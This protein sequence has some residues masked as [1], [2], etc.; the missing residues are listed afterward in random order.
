MWTENDK[1]KDIEKKH[2]LVMLFVDKSNKTNKK[3]TVMDETKVII[4]MTNAPIS[5]TIQQKA[6]NIAEYMYL[7]IY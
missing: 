6:E 1:G 3:M 2:M 5:I 4:I 7:Y